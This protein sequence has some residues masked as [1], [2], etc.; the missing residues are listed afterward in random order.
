MLTF[1]QIKNEY[2]PEI[3]QRNPKAVLIEYLQYE[4]LDSLYKQK[5]SEKLS[6][7]G[8]T[9]IRIVYN[10]QRFSEDLDFDNFG[11]NYQDFEL[12]L[13]KVMADM[14]NKGFEIEFRSLEK[15]AYHCYIKFPKLL[16]ENDLSDHRDE[17]ILVR[18]DTVL[19]KRLNEPKSFILNNFGVY[20]KILV[21]SQEVILSQKIIA[22]IERKRSKGRDY[23]DVSYL[24]GKTNPDFDYLKIVL[25]IK[26]KSE[27]KNKL[28]ETINKNNLNDLAQDVSPFLIDKNGSDRVLGFKEYIKQRVL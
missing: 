19:K 3:I 2:S 24:L 4:I 23:Y 5:N 22:I 25:K 9:A 11:L 13:E 6:F 26:E 20:R 1:E 15:G 28:I 7:M 14:R 17:K 10:S 18:I 12:L 16:F 8:G 27:I 21:N